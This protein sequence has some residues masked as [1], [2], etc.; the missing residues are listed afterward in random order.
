[1]YHLKAFH[2]CVG[3]NGCDGCINDDNEDNAGLEGIKNRL[4]SLRQR[5]NF[6]VIKKIK[7]GV[8]DFAYLLFYYLY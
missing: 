8:S 7:I 5:E 1:M 4:V 6:E 3:P 2:D